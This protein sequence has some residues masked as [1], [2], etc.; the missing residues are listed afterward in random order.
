MKNCLSTDKPFASGMRPTC[1]GK[2]FLSRLQDELQLTVWR[3]VVTLKL[4]TILVEGNR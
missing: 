1:E 2:K 3:R 4:S